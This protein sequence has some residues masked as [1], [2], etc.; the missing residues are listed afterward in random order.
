MR[1]QNQIFNLEFVNLQLQSDMFD[2][3]EAT[4]KLLEGLAWLLDNCDT[5]PPF[6][7]A[8]LDG[9]HFNN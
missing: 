3:E 5:A 1:G 4:N 6:S 9:T 7:T 8:I 2:S